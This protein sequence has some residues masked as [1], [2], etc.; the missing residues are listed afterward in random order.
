MT[1]KGKYN[2]SETTASVQFFLVISMNTYSNIQNF[3]YI[4]A[5]ICKDENNQT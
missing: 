4:C 1:Y 2:F 5:I 3:S